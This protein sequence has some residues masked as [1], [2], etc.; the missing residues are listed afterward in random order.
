MNTTVPRTRLILA[1]R[2]LTFPFPPLIYTSP[3]LSASIIS[4]PHHHSAFSTIFGRLSIVVTRGAGAPRGSGSWQ[5][6]EASTGRL[7]VESR[8]KRQ[9]NIPMASQPYFDG[10]YK[11][12]ALLFVF[13]SVLVCVLP[14][15]EKGKG[16]R[17]CVRRGEEGDSSRVLV[18][19]YL[20]VD[21]GVSSLFA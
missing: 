6:S 1:S 19:R 20:V 3:T 8:S 4:G 15:P 17:G 2:H 10:G 12:L 11:S 21:V 18:S 5:G 9:R 7:G 16:G 13:A 14:S